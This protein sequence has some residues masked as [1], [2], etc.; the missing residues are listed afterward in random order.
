MLNRACLAIALGSLALAGCGGDRVGGHSDTTRVLTLLSPI[1][2]ST[3]LVAYASEVAELSHGTLRLRILYAGYEGRRDYETATIRDL[4]RGR[5]TL[6]AAGTRAWDRLGIPQLDALNAPLLIDSYE[7]EQRVLMSDTAERALA[8]V[9]R[10]GLVPLGLLPGPLRKPLGVSHPLLTPTEYRGKSIGT[11]QSQLA[12]DTLRALGARPVQLPQTPTLPGL[13]GLEFQLTGVDGD[14]LDVPG[15]HLASN[16]NLWPR[17]FVLVT[18]AHAYATL[19]PDQKRILRTAAASVIPKL[20][21][22]MRDDETEAAGDI[23][24]RGNMTFDT[25]SPAQLQALRHRVNHVYA[26]LEHNPNTRATIAAI[27]HIK[28]EAAIPPAALPRCNRAAPVTSQTR[29]P[30]DG[31]WRMDTPPSAA[32]PDLLAENWGRW[33]FIFDHGRFA[34]TQQNA[35]ACTWGYG[36]YT[37]SGNRTTWQFTDGG[38]EAPNNAQNKPG[39]Q[40]AF[41]ISAYR[42][43]LTL[44]PIKGRIS[45]LNFRAKPWRRLSTTPSIAQLSH[46]CPPPAAALT[47]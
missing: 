47:H 16:V 1:Q 30:L 8:G 28:R 33:K 39:E 17:P 29:T 45:P 43:T 7:L 5:A 40:F 35:Q 15:S 26:E 24:R 11:Q 31:T 9:R 19:T 6:A 42:D 22:T 46:R 2:N 12:N 32:A 34:I 23:C 38:G 13:A 20:A 18:N 25:A 10:L 44:T 36:T 14:H 3:E 21:A 27:E 4:Q 41:G 37:V